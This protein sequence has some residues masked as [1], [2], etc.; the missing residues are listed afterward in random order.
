MVTPPRV[1]EGSGGCPGGQEGSEGRRQGSRVLSRRLA[2]VRTSSRWAGE[3]WEAHQFGRV[4]SGIHLGRSRGV[5][6]PI[7]MVRG[8][9][10]QP[11]GQEESGVLHGVRE[12]SQ[13][14][15]GGPEGVKR[16]SR[17]EGRGLGVL[18]DSREGLRGQK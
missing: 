10:V 7:R 14:A 6:R 1:P 9:E 18:L 5:G 12:G 16:P 11:K 8:L 15:P 2:R 13:G 17:R 3:D 4:G